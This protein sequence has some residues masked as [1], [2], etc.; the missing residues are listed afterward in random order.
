M[1]IIFNSLLNLMSSRNAHLIFAYIDPGMG[2]LVF[3]V[4]AASIISAGLFIRRAREGIIWLMTG[5]WR[6]KTLSNSEV[7][8]DGAVEKAAPMEE[9]RKVA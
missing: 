3:Q 8:P 9:R 6:N 5:G 1:A 7:L 4:V 2:S